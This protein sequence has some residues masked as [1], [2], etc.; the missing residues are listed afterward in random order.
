MLNEKI[1]IP[2]D[3]YFCP[4]RHSLQFWHFWP[5]AINILVLSQDIPTIFFFLVAPLT[6]FFLTKIMISTNLFA[7]GVLL[8][9]IASTYSNEDAHLPSGNSAV[10][11]YLRRVQ[12]LTTDNTTHVLSAVESAPTTYPTFDQSW[13]P[14]SM[15]TITMSPWLHTVFTYLTVIWP[16]LAI[17]SQ[18]A[19]TQTPTSAPSQAIVSEAPSQA[20]GQT[21]TYAPV[22]DIVYVTI[23]T[24]RPASSLHFEH[25]TQIT[26]APSSGPIQQ[27]TQLLTL[28]PSS[29][30]MQY[31]SPTPSGEPTQLPSSGQ[32]TQTPSSGQPAP[33]ALPKPA[34]SA[35]PTQYLITSPSLYPTVTNVLVSGSTFKPTGVPTHFPRKKSKKHRHDKIKFDEPAKKSTNRH[36]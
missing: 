7:V 9:L 25:P 15:P 31:P 19:L 4:S 17:S 18:E 30:P 10:R 21:P 34:P 20:L 2:K 36:S 26:A 5:P 23:N 1:F 8:V 35:Q 24:L 22:H 29:Q 16:T 11:R 33:S 3:V 12:R 6:I 13:Q 27:L 14:T 32:P 28:E